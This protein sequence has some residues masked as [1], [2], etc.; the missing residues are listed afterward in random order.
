MT[1][2]QNNRKA[3][4]TKTPDEGTPVEAA[5]AADRKVTIRSTVGYPIVASYVVPASENSAARVGDFMIVP[6]DVQLEGEAQAGRTTV[7]LSA[8]K[9]AK[10][11][12][13]A[14]AGRVERGDLHE[15]MG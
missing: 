5:A 15:I 9:A 6:K 8:W 11:A 1:S 10:A 7:S 14:I 4:A 12:N 3:A 2:R 13:P